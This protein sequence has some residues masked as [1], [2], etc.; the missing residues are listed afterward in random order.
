MTGLKLALI[1]AGSRGWSL[2]KLAVEDDARA[3]FRAIVDPIAGHREA[4]AEAF[5][6]PSERSFANHAELLAH[7]RDLDGVLLASSVAAHL[8]AACDC[9]E[10]GVP[11]FLEKPMALNLDDARKIADTAQRTGTP[12]QVG[13]NCRYTPFFAKIEEIVAQGTLGR[14]LAAE[15]KEVIGPSHWAEYCRHPSYNRRSALGRWLLEKSCHDIDLLNWIVGGQCVRVASFGSRS[16][17]LPRADVPK[18]CTP[19][20]PIESDCLF[21][22]AK[23]YSD[24]QSDTSGRSRLIPRV[25]VYHSGADLVDHQTVLLEYDNAA[26]VAFSLLPLTHDESRF[27]YLCGTDATLR[28]VAG[29][30]EIRVHPYNKGPEVVCDTT[31]PTDSHGGGDINI[32]HAFLDWLENPNRPPKTRGPEGIEAMLVCEAIKLAVEERRVVELEELRSA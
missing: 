17:F 32:I 2:A 14:I 22:A 3:C 18:E 30:N 19:A 21:S 27:V 10:A 4:F 7:C 26:T 6:I 20:C 29:R 16:H 12:L 28:A 15:W 13:F 11:V 1:G 23:L 5:S 8:Q 25:C 31:A 9:L 24:E